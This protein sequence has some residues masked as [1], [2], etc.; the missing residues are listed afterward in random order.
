MTVC[1]IFRRAL[2][3]AIPIQ[4]TR[5][6]LLNIAT[7]ARRDEDKMYATPEQIPITLRIKDNEMV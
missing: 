2:G 1:C 3:C 6:E 7:I 4:E 5:Q